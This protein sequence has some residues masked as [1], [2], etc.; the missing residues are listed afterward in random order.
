MQEVIGLFPVGD[1]DFFFVSCS[2]H[3]DQFTFHISLPSSKFTICI[4]LSLLT[5]TLTVLFLAV[6]RML[7]TYQ[8][9]LM[10]LLYMSSHSSVDRAPAQCSGSHGFDS[11][12]GLR[13]FSFSCPTLMSHRSVHFSHFI[14]F[15]A[16]NLQP[17]QLCP[18][19]Q[20][21]T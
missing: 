19:V 1:S 16:H 20:M 4:H 3:V 17:A 10:T 21:N 6:C 14:T 15:S 12:W 5:M 2:C 13:F 7:V 11:C 18:G 8:L 9:S